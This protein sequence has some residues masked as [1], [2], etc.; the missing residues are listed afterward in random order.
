MAEPI[1]MG[2]GVLLWEYAIKPIADSIKK[3]YGEES[4]KL[5]KEHL[6]KVWDKLPFS[7]TEQ[8]VIEAEICE[9]DRD[10]LGDKDKFISYIES[11]SKIPNKL[12]QNTYTI[13]SNNGGV[14]VNNGTVNITNNFNS[15]K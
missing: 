2:A 9:A 5:L 8:E 7:K 10:V 4:K 3:E 12:K 6:S 15:P 14:Q 1:S 13:D 11:N